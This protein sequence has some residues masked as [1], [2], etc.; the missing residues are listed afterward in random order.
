MTRR[1]CSVVLVI[2]AGL[3]GMASVVPSATAAG[4][5]PFRA[6]FTGQAVF[7]PTATPG[8][9]SGTGSGSGRATHLGR[10]GVSVTET[11]DVTSPTGVI[12]LRDGRMIMV[13]ANGDE[14]RWNYSGTGTPP[15][16]SG[17]VM[18][19]G[20]F[21]ITGGTGRFSSATGEGSFEGV[22]SVVTGKASISYTGIISF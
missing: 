2:A 6:D 4:T 1:M 11:L 9:L 17:D 14:L 13:A 12:A 21:L 18:L 10:V 16:A 8:I 20:T 22:G 7:T 15:D 19:S 5:R 3:F